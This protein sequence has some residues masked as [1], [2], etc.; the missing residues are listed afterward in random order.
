MENKTTV[1]EID[2]QFMDYK[3][4]NKSFGWKPKHSLNDG[5]LKSIKW[6]EKF[7]KNI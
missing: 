3:K 2:C 4:V 6:Y 1:G 7:L 5:I